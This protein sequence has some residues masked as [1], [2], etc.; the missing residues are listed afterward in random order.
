MRA[1]ELAKADGAA[2]DPDPDAERILITL[3]RTGENLT[4]CVAAALYFARHLD[5][6]CR[7]ILMTNR[8]IEDRHDC[9]ADR[10]IEQAVVIPNGRGTFV[11]E[12]IEDSRN[13]IGR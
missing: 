9:V 3:Q 1:A 10:L 4:L 7:M 13:L 8:K 6:T 5:C 2:V 12:D 11:V